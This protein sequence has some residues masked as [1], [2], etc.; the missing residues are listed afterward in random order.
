MNVEQWTEDNRRRD[1]LAIVEG[2]DGLVIMPG[3]ERLPMDRCPCCDKAFRRDA[4]GMRAA[5]LV[6][7]MLFPIAGE[8]R[9]AN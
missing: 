3:D 6:A 8:K 1:G 5:R 2:I 7:D 9:N 4:T